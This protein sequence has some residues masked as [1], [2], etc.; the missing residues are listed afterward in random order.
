MRLPTSLPTSKL[1]GSK[2]L[3]PL[4]NYSKFQIQQYKHSTFLVSF[5]I[6]RSP[7]WQWFGK[8]NEGGQVKSKCKVCESEGKQISLG[9]AKGITSSIRYHLQYNQY[10]KDGI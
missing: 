3:T 1:V 4:K 2:F 6:S 7:I 9:M 8:V 5:N 10:T